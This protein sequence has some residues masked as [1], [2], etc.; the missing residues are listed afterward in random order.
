MQVRVFCGLAGVATVN[1]ALF[2]SE[3]TLSRFSGRKDLAAALDRRIKAKGVN[4]YEVADELAIR[5]ENAEA[6]A[7]PGDRSRIGVPLPAPDAKPHLVGGFWPLYPND[8]N[9]IY[10]H[11]GVGKSLLATYAAGW[12]SERGVMPCTWTTK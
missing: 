12:L 9:C 6:D 1:G 2:T 11:G 10:S 3:I 5:V 7:H 4:W 8:A